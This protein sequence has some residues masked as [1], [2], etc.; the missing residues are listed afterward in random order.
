MELKA[1]G[2]TLKQHASN[3]W[4]EYIPND[5]TEEDVTK[6]DFWMHV[7]HKLNKGAAPDTIELLTNDLSTY[8][9]IMVVGKKSSE[10]VF[11]LIEKRKFEKVDNKLEIDNG[12]Y[13][14]EFAGQS[15]WRV[16]KRQGRGYTEITANL[17]TQSS[18]VRAVED[19]KKAMAA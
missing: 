13:V 3:T 2:L 18:G 14:V 6:A 11:R 10:L 19:H 17:P 15:G 12:L 9:R 1:S 8:F 16:L 5:A 7:S 4:F